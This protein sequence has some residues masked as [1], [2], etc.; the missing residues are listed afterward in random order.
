MSSSSNT[1]EKQNQ[2]SQ[3]PHVLVFPYPAQGH[4]LA[5]LD[6]THHLSERK[7]RITILVTEK[8]RHELRQLLSTHPATIQTLVLPFPS[9]PKLPPGVENVRDIG[10]RGNIPF[11]NALSK[12][13]D[14]IIQWFQ[15][16]ADPPVA[17]IS[18]FFLGWT[19]KLADQLRVPRISFFSIRVYTASVLDYCWRNIHTV[20]ASP[21]VHF[22][23]LPKSQS[24]KQEHLP[25]IVRLY[26]ESDP[27]MKIVQ[28]AL[29]ANIQSWA[30]VFNSFDALEGEY[31]EDLVTKT[32]HHRVYGVGPLSLVGERESESLDDANSDVWGWLDEC[33]EGSVLYVC[34]GSQKLLNGKQM[35]ALASGLERSR[36]RFLWVVKT[37]GEEGYGVVPEGFEERVQ[38]RGLVVKAW[39]PQRAI[40]NHRAV[41]GFL[42]HCGWNS[43]LEGIVAGVI[44]L[45]WPME[46]DQFLNAR[47]LVEDV[48]TSVTVCEGADAVPDS[49]Q[50]GKVIAQSMSWDSPLKVKATE[51]MN[52]AFAAVRPGGSSFTDLEHLAKELH[53]LNKT[54]QF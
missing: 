4:S 37:G 16:H 53:Q 10:N 22:H 46:A 27:D 1:D 26:D 54:G 40:L 11:I 45:G 50:L 49:A 25:S 2:A 48:G 30:C 23:Q 17:I 9:H 32:G 21:I 12:L 42:S 13:R 8:N 29:T 41:G 35:E 51:L 38:G 43:V 14:P 3:A 31:L 39:A 34:F 47:L 7:V 52:K 36:T 15:S 6:L 5:L 19:Q 44:V 24:F 28:E 20:R 18:D 33:P